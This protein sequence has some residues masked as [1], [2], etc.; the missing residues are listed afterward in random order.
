[1]LTE[2]EIL[3]EAQIHADHMLRREEGTAALRNRTGYEAQLLKTLTVIGFALLE[4]NRIQ[5]RAA[6]TPR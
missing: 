6:S 3:H 2:R 5:Y 4:S 1:M